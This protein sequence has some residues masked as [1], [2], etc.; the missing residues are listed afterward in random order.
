MTD[1]ASPSSRSAGVSPARPGA[2]D[3]VGFG[4][5]GAR[6][7]IGT[8]AVMPAIDSAV[9]ATMAAVSARSGPVDER[10]RKAEVES[11]Q[12]VIDHPAVE[13]VYIPLPN[14]RHGEWIRRA[15]D[16]G[17]HVL[18]EKP[19][20]PTGG[21]AHELMSYCAAAG[22]VLAEAWMTPFGARWA[23]AMR[24]GGTGTIGDVHTIQTA[25]TF[26]IG[27][28]NESNYRWD[29]ADGGGALLDVGIYAIGPAV[30]C[31]G[32]SPDRVTAVSNFSSRG[33]DVTTNGSLQWNDGRRCDFEVSFEQAERQTIRIIGTEGSIT[34]DN[35]AHTGNPAATALRLVVNGREEERQISGSDPYT[36]M[37]E[38]L[39]DAIRGR[40]E[41]PRSADDTVALLQLLDRLAAE[42]RS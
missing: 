6:S 14:G 20:A 23:E 10:W 37:I 16:A 5:L 28:G 2:P 26:T 15:A 11:Y 42:A 27:A 3:P 39:A 19:L 35:E 22:V 29:P 1:G 41:W 33:V 9:N 21:E 13:V 12:A 32:A 34:I 25:F 38:S 31:W 7:F 8:K 36:A 17:K 18:C 40:M 4:A 24:L 30:R